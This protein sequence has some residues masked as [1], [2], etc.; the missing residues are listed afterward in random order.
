MAGFRTEANEWAFHADHRYRACVDLRPVSDHP[1]RIGVK[2]TV[3]V[4]GFP[5]RLGLRRYRHHPRTSAAPLA[6]IADQLVT[7]KVVT[8]ELN[9]GVGSG[10][11]NPCFP[12]VD[13]AGSSTGSGVAV[14]AGIC[15]L[16][17]GTDVLGSVRWP[18]GRTGTVA[19]RVTHDDRLLPGIFP[20]SPAM[21]APGWVARTAEDLTFL[22]AHLGLGP[23]GRRE[24]PLRVGVV[25]EVFDGHADSEVLTSLETGCRALRERGHTV[26]HVRVGD[27]WQ[28]RAPAWELCARDAWDGYRAWREW[29]PEELLESTT[30]ALE[31]GASVGDER[32]GEIVDAMTRHRATAAD[33]FRAHDVDAWLLPLDA[34]HPRLL[35]TPRSSGST[36]PTPD[37]PDYDRRVGYTP[38]ASFAGLPAATFPVELSAAGAP[39]ALQA[40]GPPGAEAVLLRLARDV[41]TVLGELDL[42]PR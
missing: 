21:D 38:L 20:L 32:R 10:C 8:T 23:A 7:A 29:L 37:D 12:H 41:A 16:S 40:V 5:T 22:L 18:A 27:L 36:V 24:E 6:P 31:T 14:A 11:V 15:D 30:A 9:I 25:A 28:W 39:L 4:A 13:P 1:V 34:A 19:L 3:D 2:D 42:T 17:L 33:Q 26:S 35:D